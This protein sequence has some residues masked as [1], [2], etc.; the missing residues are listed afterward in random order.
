MLQRGFVHTLLECL[1]WAK[2]VAYNT[3]PED[4]ASGRRASAMLLLSTHLAGIWK[5]SNN[6]LYYQRSK[7]GKNHQLT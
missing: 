7:V 4:A 1:R 2:S 5:S 3:P 6:Q